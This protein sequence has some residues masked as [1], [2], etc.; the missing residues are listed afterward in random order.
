MATV[1]PRHTSVGE[2][3]QAGAAA[4]EL[5]ASGIRAG[6]PRR[7]ICVVSLVGEHD[8]HTAPKAR[9]ELRRVIAAGARAVVVDLTETTFL[10][11]T[12][13]SL[14]L[15]LRKELRAGGRLLLVTD[16]PRVRRVFEIAGVDRFFDFFPSR[17][18]AE[19]EARSS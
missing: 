16:E 1:D 17:R 12:V 14:L 2:E 7:D 18:A 9:E 13:L 3:P 4:Q 5:I 11:S 8:L 6:W 10:D 19:E 15:G